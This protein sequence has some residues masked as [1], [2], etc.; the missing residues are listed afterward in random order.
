MSRADLT[1]QVDC[2]SPLTEDF[3]VRAERFRFAD[4]VP[5]CRIGYVWVCCPCLAIAT[6]CC[7]LSAGL[8]NL[9]YGP[10]DGQRKFLKNLRK[11]A[12]TRH[13]LFAR[14][15]ARDS[16]CGIFIILNPPGGNFAMQETRYIRL[17]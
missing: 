13:L 1:S 10:L 8:H 6:I 11:K 16:F 12:L 15:G 14:T 17:V 4:N 9:T 7:G 5:E 3:P 2:P